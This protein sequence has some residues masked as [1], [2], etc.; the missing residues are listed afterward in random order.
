VEHA[1]YQR[2][3]LDQPAKEMVLL[4]GSTSPPRRIA[5]GPGA[6][7]SPSRDR[8]PSR[9]SDD[10]AVRSSSCDRPSSSTLL[11][12]GKVRIYALAE[13][14]VDLQ[15][16]RAPGI[17]G[18]PV[19][20]CAKATGRARL[21]DLPEVGNKRAYWTEVDPHVFAASGQLV[22]YAYT[23][24][25]L[26]THET[27]VRVRNLRSG[28]ILRSCAAGGDIA[29][30][31]LPRVMRILLDARGA[32]AW[33]A[34][35]GL[36]HVVWVCGPAGLHRLDQGEGVDLESLTLEKGVLHWTSEGSGR[37]ASLE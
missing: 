34:E 6:G 3:T 13:K 20:G 35:A 19:F 4:D 11:E 31:R 8:R 12:T 1:L 18:R 22:A 17:G 28:R 9:T 15:G 14:S 30:G 33:S 24:Y 26:D 10:N 5:P 36:G 7:V 27:W 37:E 29:P 2:V 23:Q 16:P 25:Y 21:L 32:V